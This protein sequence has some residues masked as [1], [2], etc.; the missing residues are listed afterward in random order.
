MAENIRQDEN[1]CSENQF[2]DSVHSDVVRSILFSFPAETIRSCAL[3]FAKGKCDMHQVT[4]HTS[5]FRYKKLSVL[6][7]VWA[8][9]HSYSSPVV[10]RPSSRGSWNS[11]KTSEIFLFARF[12]NYVCY[13]SFM[14]ILYDWSSWYLPGFINVI[15]NLIPFQIN[16]SSYKTQ[17]T[18]TVGSCYL[19]S[20]YM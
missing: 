5:W 4:W 12:C 19:P 7:I 20:A 10:P 14:T 9:I 8:G 6:I 11:G 3:K 18:L 16:T 1:I 17:Q 2:C 15:C 13:F